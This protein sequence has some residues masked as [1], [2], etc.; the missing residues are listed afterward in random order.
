MISWNQHISFMSH[1]EGA[2]GKKVYHICPLGSG[3]KPTRQEFLLS[4]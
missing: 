2:F 1:A 4:D 3:K